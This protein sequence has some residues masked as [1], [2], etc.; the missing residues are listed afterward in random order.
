M[1]DDFGGGYQATQHLLKF[2]HRKIAFLSDELENPF[3]FISMRLRYDGYRRALAEAGIPFQE[4]YHQ[5]GPHGREKAAQ[6]AK[7]LLCLADPP[8]AIF[9]ASDTQASGVLDAA[10][11]LEIQIP[12]QLSIIGYDDIEL[13]EYMNLST[14]RQPLF[15]TGVRG[16]EIL[17]SA[18]EGAKISMG[19]PQELNLPFEL[20]PRGTT[21]PIRTF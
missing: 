14:I 2:G 9:A 3:G 21:G 5:Q 15:E 4:R 18:L 8:S 20:I 1:V 11:E 13:A 7:Q 12:D 19:R 6:M 10:R 17:L 16:A